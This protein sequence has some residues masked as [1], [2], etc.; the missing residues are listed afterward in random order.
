[1]S[2]ELIYACKRGDMA[3]FEELYNKYNQKV[4]SIAFNMLGTE[5]D[6]MDAV[7]EIFIKVFKSIRSFRGNSAFSTWLYRVAVNVCYDELRKRNRLQTDSIEW[8]AE[9]GHELQS[10]LP[11]PEEQVISSVK[12]DELKTAIL[13]LKEDYRVVLILRDVIGLSYDAI[14]GIL[15]LPV[16]TV[17]SRIAR[18][19]DAAMEK[20]KKKSEL[21]EK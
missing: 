9:N 17:K 2:D 16:G 1:M 20:I 12:A 15:F 3:A 18:A 21:F 19:R 6:A 5:A 4:Y 10:N 13:S 7:Q 8:F 14:A 11:L